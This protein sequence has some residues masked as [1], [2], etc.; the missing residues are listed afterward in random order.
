MTEFVRQKYSLKVRSF[1]ARHTSTHSSG[2][3]ELVALNADGTA[4]PTSLVAP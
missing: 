3:N 2:E 1:T 4:F